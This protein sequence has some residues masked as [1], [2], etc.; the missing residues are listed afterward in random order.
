[1]KY[2]ED[3]SHDEIHYHETGE[4]LCTYCFK[5]CA[6]QNIEKDE[7]NNDVCPDCAEEKTCYECGTITKSLVPHDGNQVCTECKSLLIS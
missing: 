3:W 2:P 1:M 6:E 7:H 4:I 5:Y